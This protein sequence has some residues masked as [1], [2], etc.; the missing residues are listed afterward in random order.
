MTAAC[1][2]PVTPPH[3]R[4]HDQ[5]C[6]HAPGQALPSPTHRHRPPTADPLSPTPIPALEQTRSDHPPV[7]LPRPF[8]RPMHRPMA[9]GWRTQDRKVLQPGSDLG[10]RRGRPERRAV[11]HLEDARCQARRIP[12]G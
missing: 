9:I 10:R 5:P 12:A 2:G 7:P 11:V 3:P 1:G 6:L 8:P 4:P